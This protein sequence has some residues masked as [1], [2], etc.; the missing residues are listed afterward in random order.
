MGSGKSTVGKMIAEKL[1]LDFVDL[2]QFIEKKE[3]RSISDIFELEGERYFREIELKYLKE[4]LD[5]PKRKVIA[6]GG[7]TPCSE[8]SWEILD[9]QYTVYLKAG[10]NKLLGNLINDKSN[11]RPLLKGKSIDELLAFII[12]KLRERVGFYKRAKVRKLTKGSAQEVADRVSKSIVKS[13]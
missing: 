5:A 11:M 10:A 6:L 8:A 7:G 9:D 4:L 12:L 13:I 2:D 1:I 3:K